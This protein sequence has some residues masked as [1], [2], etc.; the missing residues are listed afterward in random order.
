MRARR[1]RRFRAAAG[2]RAAC[3]AASGIV[4][5]A[6]HAADIFGLD[7]VE[8]LRT[9]RLA[10]S[11]LTPSAGGRSLTRLLLVRGDATLRSAVAPLLRWARE[12]WDSSNGAR[13][14]M[15]IGQLRQAWHEARPGT[16]RRWGDVQGPMSAAVLAAK[17]V[18]LEMSG[19]FHIRNAS[20]ERLALT[21]TSPGLIF[22]LVEIEAQSQLQ[23]QAGK[24]MQKDGMAWAAEETA[25]LLGCPQSSA[26]SP[27]AI[28]RVL[29]EKGTSALEAGALAAVACNAVW[30]KDRLCRAGLADDSLCPLCQEGR[31]TLWH[32]LGVLRVSRHSVRPCHKTA[33]RASQGCGAVFPSVVGRLA[34]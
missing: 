30:T 22:K 7:D 17:R 27:L 8:L 28:C 9:R 19:P 13:G 1:F 23:D 34:A 31:D 20:R 16:V 26:P 6:G 11:V 2:P 10:A 5:A 12:V 4:P 32:S 24:Q 14:A 33:D 29:R 21:S 25:A 18:G 15:R 3:L